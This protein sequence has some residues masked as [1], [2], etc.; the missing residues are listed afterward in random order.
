MPRPGIE[1]SRFQQ[2]C[3]ITFPKCVTSFHHHLGLRVVPFLHTLAS[4]VSFQ[5]EMRSGISLFSFWF[6][7]HL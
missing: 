3:Q 1:A 4:T 6:S 5:S 2:C 7:D